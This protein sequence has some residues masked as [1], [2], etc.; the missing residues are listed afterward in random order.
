MANVQM[1]PFGNAGPP[2][3]FADQQI[4]IIFDPTQYIT[5]HR[6]DLNPFNEIVEII[7][8]QNLL[9]QQIQANRNRKLII[10]FIHPQWTHAQVQGFIQQHIAPALGNINQF[11]FFYI[12]GQNFAA[13]LMN[14]LSVTSRILASTRETCQRVNTENCTYYGREQNLYHARGDFGIAYSY[15]VEMDKCTRM[16]SLYNER[17]RLEFGIRRLRL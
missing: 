14:S 16:N 11:S 13:Q 12:D 10:I 2:Q 17:L 15:A 5:D 6:M 7:T 4:I 1:I 9:L 3:L 8:N